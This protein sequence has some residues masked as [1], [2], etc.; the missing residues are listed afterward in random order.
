M[1]RL[2]ILAIIPEKLAITE[3]DQPFGYNCP[4]QDY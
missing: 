2:I 3:S 1:M 4:K